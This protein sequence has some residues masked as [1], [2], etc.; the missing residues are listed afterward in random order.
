MAAVVA[1]CDHPVARTR[2][3]SVT[4]TTADTMP[5]ID[6]SDVEGVTVQVASGG[7]GTAQ[8]DISNDGVNFVG[9]SA[10]LTLAAAAPMAVGIQSLAIGLSPKFLRVSAVAAATV[11]ITITGQKR[12]IAT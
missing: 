8:I 10:T 11:T 4:L 7:A 3:W 12:G 9:L 5:A 2:V 6:I 1:K